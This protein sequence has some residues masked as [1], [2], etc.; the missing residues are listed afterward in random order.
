MLKTQTDTEIIVALV[1]NPNTGKSTLF[2]ALSGMNQRT[3]NYPGVTVEKK[4]GRYQCDRRK[5]QVIDLPGTYS[6]GPKSPDETIALKVLL[7]RQ[8]DVP[9]PDVIVCVADAN[10]LE[11]NLFLVSQATDLGATVILALNMV[12]VAARNGVRVDVDLLSRKLDIPVVPIQANKKIGIGDLKARI[13]QIAET[14]E[15]STGHTFP[16]EVEQEIDGIREAIDPLRCNPRSRFLAQ[17]LLLDGSGMVG[18]VVGPNPQLEAVVNE[19]RQ[20]LSD[21]GVQMAAVE[22]I[23]RY[24]AITELTQQAI[25]RPS[26]PPRSMTDRIDR[27]LTHRVGGSLVFV[28]VMIAIFQ[29]I[30]VWSVPLMDGIDALVGRASVAAGNWLPAG[31]LRSLVTDGVIAGVGSVI[32]FLP[33]ILILFLFIALLE[34][35]GYMARAAYLMDKVMSRIGLSGKSFIPLLSSFGCAIPGIMATRTIEN[36]RDRLITML[37][38]PLMSCSAR[39]PVYILLIAAFVPQVGLLGGWVSLQALVMFSMYVIG[40][41][42]AMAMAWLLRR[43]ILKGETPTF[44]ME[45]PDYKVPSLK[46]A[47]F[48]MLE[49]AGA[50]VKRAGTLIFAVAIVV[51]ALSYFPHPDS[52]RQQVESRYASAAAFAGDEE[53]RQ[54]AIARESSAAYLRQSWLAR[55]G[56]LIEP[57][58]VPLGWDWKVA[59]AVVASFPAR[60]VVVGTLGVLYNVGD[61]ADENSESLRQRLKNAKWDGTERKVFNLPMALG[62]MVFFALCAQCVSTLAIMARETG[63]YRWPLFT[64][65]YM[66]LLAWLGALIVYQTGMML[67]GS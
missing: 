48:R 4:V 28:A 64:F 46:N 35:C 19:A 54:A 23:S 14:G 39:L 61:E 53:A 65:V 44:V 55:V 15:V 43:T 5:F 11:R 67:T 40:V 20:R 63:G 49:Q 59:A 12:D 66:T 56:R 45:L 47:L 31:A 62:L 13:C 2:N 1:G 51:W 52:I 33:Q 24:R 25:E 29:A 16:A 9:E 3:G 17:R 34:D 26:V 60:E 50:F 8:P 18:R 30:F 58:V 6:L 21:G 36:W 22:S 7:G 42:V 10:N 41:V 38:A 32:I 37:V 57:A 27:I